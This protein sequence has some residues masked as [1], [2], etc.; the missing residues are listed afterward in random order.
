MI[1]AWPH[2]PFRENRPHGFFTM[3]GA[4][5]CE[6]HK[7]APCAACKPVARYIV[8]KAIESSDIGDDRKIIH[9]VDDLDL[10]I[11][12][13]RPVKHFGVLVCE[14]ME[15][16]QEEINTAY[17]NLEEYLRMM[18]ENEDR[19]FGATRQHY[20]LSHAQIAVDYFGETRT[21]AAESQVKQACEA[22]ATP[23]FI[24][25]A[26]CM[27]VQCGCVL[28]WQRAR[29]LSVLRPDELAFGLATGKL[30]R[31]PGLDPEPPPPA[32]PPKQQG[33]RV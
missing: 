32:L 4:P 21:W 16:T 22:C 30:Q 24:Y 20:N 29:E 26:R 13:A 31:I 17:A 33:A 19:I 8:K 2:P 11:D 10:A 15:P 18:K 3:D 1:S 25:A 12:L 14:G 23:N 5:K 28:N 9:V 27:N 6:K 7:K